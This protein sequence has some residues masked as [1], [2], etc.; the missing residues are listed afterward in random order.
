MQHEILLTGNKFN[1]QFRNDISSLQVAKSMD[2]LKG[3]ILLIKH[4]SL[5]QLGF[6]EVLDKT[7]NLFPNT[8]NENLSLATINPLGDEKNEENNKRKLQLQ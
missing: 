4:K 3:D 2:I 6:K 7:V 5:P 1:E 8:G